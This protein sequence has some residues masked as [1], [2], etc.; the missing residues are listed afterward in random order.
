MSDEVP[1]LPAGEAKEQFG[2]GC[3]TTMAL[4]GL[5]VAVSGFL[6]LGPSLR[7]LMGEGTRGMLTVQTRDCNITLCNWSGSFVSDDRRLQ[8]AHVE[9]ADLAGGTRPGEH[10]AVIDVDGNI[11]GAE[12]STEWLGDAGATLVGIL[13][14]TWTIWGWWSSGHSLQVRLWAPRRRA[15]GGRH[16]RPLQ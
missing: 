16:A 7:A 8:L 13:V 1:S 14:I 2:L 4:V 5:V 3:A 10:V 9:T 12:G 11:Y 15:R 6:A